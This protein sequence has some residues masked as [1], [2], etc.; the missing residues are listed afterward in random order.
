MSLLD[1][2]GFSEKNLDALKDLP[3]ADQI[4]IGG[5]MVLPLFEEAGDPKELASVIS[6]VI[7]DK[8]KNV[9]TAD[10]APVV[11][12][13]GPVM[14]IQMIAKMQQES[15]LPEKI[16]QSV[17]VNK[18]M[19]DTMD[20]DRFV[21]VNLAIYKMLPA[22]VRSL[23]AILTA[24]D[25]KSTDAEIRKFYQKYKTTTAEQLI[26]EKTRKAAENQANF[27]ALRKIALSIVKKVSPE[28]LE[29]LQAALVTKLTDKK[30]EALVT[31]GI[32]TLK[33]FFQNAVEG[34][35]FTVN[36]PAQAAKFRRKVKGVLTDLESAFV[37]AGLTP[38]ADLVATLTANVRPGN[39]G[40]AG[41]S[42]PRLQ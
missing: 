16:R 41:P 9:D 33:D 30:V 13:I 27:L 5:A 34:N 19:V 39:K 20:E 1:N 3:L 38:D 7:Q 29:A 6:S 21:A 12:M 31:I 35:V 18:S 15:L 24:S 42:V 2:L 14:V 25:A 23:I 17:E 26:E 4:S 40:K 37:E 36:D 8:I 10:I 28:S 11:S 22:S 32:P